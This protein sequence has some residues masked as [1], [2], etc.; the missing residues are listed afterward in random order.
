MVFYGDKRSTSNKE[1][2]RDM[3][4]YD[5]VGMWTEKYM[6]TYSSP[7]IVQKSRPTCWFTRRQINNT[8][9]SYIPFVMVMFALEYFAKHYKLCKTGPTMPW[10]HGGMILIYH[11]LREVWCFKHEI[12]HS[13]LYLSKV[14]LSNIDTWLVFLIRAW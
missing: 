4:F 13:G 14:M 3:G 5:F 1:L 11:R 7:D 2:S 9:S 10:V 6:N 12:Y 8:L